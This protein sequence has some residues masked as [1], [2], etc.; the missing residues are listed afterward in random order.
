MLGKCCDVVGDQSLDDILHGRV[1][2]LDDL[3]QLVD[4]R[5]IG[6][7]IEV[8]EKCLEGIAH[9]VH[10]IRSNNLGNPLMLALV[11]EIVGSWGCLAL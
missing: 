4:G 9:S 1:G 7:H 8:S 3:E 11:M 2:T 6:T 10:G 5:V